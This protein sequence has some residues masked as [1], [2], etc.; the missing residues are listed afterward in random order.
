[1]MMD[2]KFSHPSPHFGVDEEKEKVI[3]VNSNLMWQKEGKGCD[4][5]LNEKRGN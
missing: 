1:M 3:N 5:W 4:Y 2:N